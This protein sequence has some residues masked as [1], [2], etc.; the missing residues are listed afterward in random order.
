MILSRTLSEIK[1]VS[2]KTLATSINRMREKPVIVIVD[3]I[4]TMPII[5]ACED[6]GCELIVAKNFASTNTKIRLLSL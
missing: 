2:A 5:A 1:Q 6:A 4:A 3:G